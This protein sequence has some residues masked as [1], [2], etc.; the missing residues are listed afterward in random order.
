M[1]G[2]SVG[3]IKYR[4]FLSEASESFHVQLRRYYRRGI[5][6]SPC[7]ILAIGINEH[8]TPIVVTQLVVAYPVHS[9]HKRLILDGAS[10]KQQV[11][12]LTA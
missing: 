2:K 5:I 11:P 3:I 7:Y 10:M 1:K 4:E 9:Y 12:Y 8:C 6:V